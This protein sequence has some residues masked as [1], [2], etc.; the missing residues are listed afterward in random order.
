LGNQWNWETFRLIV[1]PYFWSFFIDWGLYIHVPLVIGGMITW[2]KGTRELHWSYIVL[3]VLLVGLAVNGG[4]MGNKTYPI[5]FGAMFVVVPLA[6]R[7]LE[8]I[9]RKEMEL[10][11][12]VS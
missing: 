2:A 9:E 4:L 8:K 5:M 7:I 3:Y 10:G 6:Q 1:A 11:Y 12:E